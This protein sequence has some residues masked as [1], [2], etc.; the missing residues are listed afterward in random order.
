[1]T[2]YYILALLPII[3]FFCFFKDEKGRGLYALATFFTTLLVLMVLRDYRV[4]VDL[5]GTQ[6]WASGYKYYFDK[7]AAARWGE[8][9]KTVL[10]VE[11]GYIVL[12]KLI[13]SIS[14]DFR[15]FLLVVAV[16][17]LIPWFILYIKESPNA[18][19]T[20]SLFLS[21]APFS[22]YFSGL[23]QIIAMAFVVPAYYCCKK[24]KPILFIVCVLCATLFHNSALL[25]FALYP[26][27]KIKINVKLWPYLLMGVGLLALLKEPLFELV[28]WLLGGKYG[29]VYGSLE[30][31]GAYEMFLLFIIFVIYAYVMPSSR[32][33]GKC[34][35]ELPLALHA[36]SDRL[37]EERV[38]DKDGEGLRNV[39]WLILLIMSFTSVHTLVMRTSYYFLPLVPIIIPKLAY[40]RKSKYEGLFRLSIIVMFVFFT[41]YFLFGDARN[42]DILNIFPYI[43][44]WRG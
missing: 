24:D 39:L 1:M 29:K 4:G 7:L 36:Y 3:V 30:R 42:G 11:K 37:L 6:E 28:V 40:A 23:R 31:T 33:N 34:N 12:N 2:A 22:M 38:L 9:F 18:L 27:Y 16:I 35:G 41:A 25:I 26:L 20:I 8:I 13:S 44:F 14:Y 21:V 32:G 5:M 19:L 43:P 15:F 10:Y 17:A